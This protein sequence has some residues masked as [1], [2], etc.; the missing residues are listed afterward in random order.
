MRIPTYKGSA[1]D[2]GIKLRELGAYSAY[3]GEE[4]EMW[5]WDADWVGLSP[6]R[7][8]IDR[9]QSIYNSFT[10]PEKHIFHMNLNPPEEDDD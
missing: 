1:R 10:T 4:V 8:Q 9:I 7:R 2:Y 6:S 5:E 3:D